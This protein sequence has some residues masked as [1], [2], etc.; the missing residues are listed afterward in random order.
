MAAR[1]YKPG[2]FFRRNMLERVANTNWDD[3]EVQDEN[4]S[5]PGIDHSPVD[6]QSTG[7]NLQQNKDV[8]EGIVLQPSKNGKRKAGDRSDS[9]AKKAKKW[10]WTP[11]AVEL[12]LKYT[13][14]YKTKCE[15]NGV[16][17]EADLATMYTDRAEASG[18]RGFVSRDSPRDN[19]TH[20][21]GGYLLTLLGG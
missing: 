1:G 7:E 16:D 10:A 3:E 5:S 20:V 17:F 9:S 19:P 12:L 11:E 2:E 14:E 18:F 21:K 4:D 13:K 6:V 15:F 8:S